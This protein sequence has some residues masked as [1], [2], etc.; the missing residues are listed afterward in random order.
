MRVRVPGDKSI[1]QRALILSSLAEG[2]S[3]VRGLLTG[4][5]PVSTASALRALGVAIPATKLWKE[6]IRIRGLGLRG[7]S[8]PGAH[9]DL[10]NS[11]TG[12]RL[13][14]GV[15]AGQAIQAVVTGDES[16]R[17]R[18]MSRITDPLSSMGARFEALG[19][20]GRLPIRVVGGRLRP[21]EYRMPVA[22]AQLKSALLLAG[23][24]GGV[25]VSLQEPSRS[26]DHTESM[27]RGAGV[28]VQSGPGEEG[29]NV[30]LPIRGTALRALDIDVPGDISSAAFFMLL[31]LLRGGDEP[32]ILEGVGLNQTRTGI[33]TVLHRMGA[34]IRLVDQRGEDSGEGMGDL[35]VLPSEL[36]GTAVGGSEI[37]LLID[38]IPVLVV[39]ALRARGETRITGAG[40]LRVKETDRIRALVDNLRALGVEVEELDDGLVIEGTDRPL[41]GSVESFGDHRIAMAFGILGALP[42]NAIRV[43]GAQVAGVSFPGFWELLEKLR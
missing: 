42:G 24:V 8:S 29:W 27:L 23:L 7:Y 13:L 37:P 25:P 40:E 22:S 20:P 34:E 32:L 31:G 4:G 12:A 38:E 15:L 43:R 33:L 28:P 6:E 16:L 11:G 5:D 17:S 1:S 39:G 3:R 19:E 14:L 35:V 18:P 30:S 9:L 26:R 10:G 21:L 36:R 2:E 41:S